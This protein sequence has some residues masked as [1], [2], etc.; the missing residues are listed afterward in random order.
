MARKRKAS[1]SE[2]TFDEFL[3]GQCMPESCE[4]RAVKELIAEHLAEAIEKQGITK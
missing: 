3:A 1:V 2:E 4:D